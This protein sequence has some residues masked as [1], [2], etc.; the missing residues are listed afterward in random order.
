MPCVHDTMGIDW[1]DSLEEEMDFTAMPAWFETQSAPTATTTPVVTSPSTGS[2]AD[3]RATT[4]SRDDDPARLGSA[5]I[6]P[7]TTAGVVA[8]GDVWVRCSSVHHTDSGGR[9]RCTGF[10]TRCGRRRSPAS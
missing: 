9:S 2:D 6:T 8:D 7:R 5:P 4:Q 10:C 3:D 1:N